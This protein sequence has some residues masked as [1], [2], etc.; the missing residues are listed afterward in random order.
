MRLQVG[1]I[2]GGILAETRCF[3][4]ILQHT[5][6][7]AVNVGHREL[8]A[9]YA[10]DNLLHLCRLSGLHQIV[11]SLHFRD[12]FQSFTDTNPIGH[13][14]TFKAPIVAQDA[15]Q[16]VAI[17]HRELTI[18]LI[19][20]CHDRPRVTLSDCNLKPTQVKLTGCPLRHSFVDAGTFSLLRIHG[21]VLGR[22]TDALALNAIYVGGGNLSR[23]KRILRIV[24]EVTSTERTTMQVHAWAKDDVAT[25]LLGF[26]ANSLT[27]LRDQFRV[28]RRCQTSADG[29][30]CGI[31]RLSSTLASRVDTNTG[32]AIGEHRSRN[33]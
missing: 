18:N 8:S 7:I 33:A 3:H 29:E 27:Y 12:S 19:I 15:G 30:S 13:H 21:K 24:F 1:L 16:Q 23:H 32:R 11:A 31:I 5:A 10:L 4:N 20:R 2:S 9:L 28:P 26:I 25:I 22:H 14:D 17:A 6:N